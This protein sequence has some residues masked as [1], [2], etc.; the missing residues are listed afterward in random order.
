MSGGKA[1]SIIWLPFTIGLMGS[2]AYC[3]RMD[4]LPKSFFLS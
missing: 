1:I 4:P 3:M 2:F